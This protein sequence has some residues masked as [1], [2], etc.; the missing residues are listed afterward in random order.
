[1]SGVDEAVAARPAHQP[2][3]ALL[4]VGMQRVAALVGLV[5]IL[6]LLLLIAI[7]IRC[8]SRGP[9]I[10]RQTRI[11]QYGLPFTIYKFRTMRVGAER[12]LLAVL[13]A[14]GQ[15]EFTP[16][17]KIKKDPRVT[18]LG[19]FLRK[20][21]LDELPQLLNVVKGDMN[22]VGPRPQTPLEVSLYDGQAWRRL[23]VRPGIT[24]LWQ[25]SG[26]SE[27]SA[28]D[29]LALDD[30]YVRTWTPMLDVRLLA[31]TASVLLTQ[32]GAY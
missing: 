13:A 25:V 12:E 30:E 11:G 18:S 19:R 7:A 24:G 31:R 27:L 26:R 5:L 29:G 23:L 1:V 32:R 22:L 2:V 3:R 9:A 8:T 15:H 16:Y 20:T 10:Y 17:A 14:E 4:V 21:S 28:D 6:P